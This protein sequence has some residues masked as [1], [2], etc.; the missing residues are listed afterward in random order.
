[1]ERTLPCMTLSAS[2]MFGLEVCL[3]SIN[4]REGKFDKASR[5]LWEQASP[6][7]FGCRLR[8]CGERHPAVTRCQTHAHYRRCPPYLQLLNPNK[9]ISASNSDVH[10][11]FVRWSLEIHLNFFTFLD[12]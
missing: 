12:S 10:E 1:M 4:A 5:E 6:D 3:G 8:L 7:S 9:T 11:K 2:R